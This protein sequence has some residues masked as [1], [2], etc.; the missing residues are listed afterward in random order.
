MK[1]LTSDLKLIN[2]W[3]GVSSVMIGSVPAHAIYF[4]VYEFSRNHFTIES[5]SDFYLF[6]TM[7]TGAVANFAHD[8]IMTPMDGKV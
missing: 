1:H 6:S 5:N 3:K 4:S 2:L 7:T 8:L